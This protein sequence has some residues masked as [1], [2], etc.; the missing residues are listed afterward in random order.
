MDRK[1]EGLQRM[2]ISINRLKGVQHYV[3]REELD[4]QR[5]YYGIAFPQQPTDRHQT[6]AS[7]GASEENA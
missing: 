2:L 7:E 4:H 6:S 3:P 5:L 1:T